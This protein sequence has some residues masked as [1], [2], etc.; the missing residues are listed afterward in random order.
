MSLSPNQQTVIKRASRNAVQ[1]EFANIA[2]NWENNCWLCSRNRYRT[3][4]IDR[5]K[6]DTR[7]GNSVTHRHLR[8]YIAA[9]SMTHCLDGWSYLGRAIEAHLK[10]DNDASRHLGYY[11]EL[12]A[13]M[14]LLAAEGIGIFKNLHFIVTNNSRRSTEIIRGSQTHKFIWDALKY[15]AGLPSASN[16]IFEIIRPG[17]LPLREWLEHF[18][19]GSGFRLSI[20]EKWLSQWGIDLKRYADDRE[21]R[22]LASYRPTAFTSPP[23]MNIREAIGFVNNLWEI[24]EPADSLRF[25][26]L[27]RYLLRQ[28]LELV[29]HN[30]HAYNR[31]RGQAKVQYKHRVN[32]ML[33]HISPKDLVLPKDLVSTR[34]LASTR[35]PDDS[36]W[37][38]FL[39]YESFGQPSLILQEAKGTNKSSH[40]R[41]HLQVL[42]RA[43]LL[44]R[45]ASGAC[46]RILESLPD[47]NRDDLE[48]WWSTTGRE[49]A[50]WHTEDEPDDFVDLWAD[51][52]EAITELQQWQDSDDDKS[53]YRVWRDYPRSV[54]ILGTCER[55]ALWGLGL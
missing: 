26:I 6:N 37:K 4:C 49:R 9:S 2:V 23:A 5:L 7:S 32:S 29:F 40:P 11:A 21:A 8:E 52:D 42:S 14:A 27:D 31:T 50:L 41:H 1:A 28:S 48:F 47:F 36:E 34:D 22:N 12:R 46:H 24:C 53:Y 25:P 43:T 10:G 51:V 38:R 16:L 15:W 30:S 3:A 18:A 17:G 39:C 13:A 54:G 35:D 55:I 45:L 19:V 20:T 33:H 44:L